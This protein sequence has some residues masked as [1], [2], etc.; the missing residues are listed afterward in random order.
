M[1]LTITIS[2]IDLNC[3]PSKLNRIVATSILEFL[4]YTDVNN[5]QLG[6]ETPAVNDHRSTLV[7]AVEF[8]LLEKGVCRQPPVFRPRINNLLV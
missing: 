3:S 6:R 5:K 1:T 2:H 7:M 8:A 4:K